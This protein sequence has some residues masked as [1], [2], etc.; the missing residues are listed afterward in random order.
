MASIR[1]VTVVHKGFIFRTMCMTPELWDKGFAILNPDFRATEAELKKD[2]ERLK[3][4]IRGYVKSEGA[5]NV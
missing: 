4:Y 2:E 1:C 3:F 5:V